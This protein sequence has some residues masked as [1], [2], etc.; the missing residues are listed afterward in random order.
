MGVGKVS[1]KF[2]HIIGIAIIIIIFNPIFRSFNVK[3]ASAD[4]DIVLH[5]PLG[6]AVHVDDLQ[7]DRGHHASGFQDP[8]RSPRILPIPFQDRRSGIRNG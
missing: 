1:I 6:D 2:S 3:P 8:L 5:E 4:E 7:E